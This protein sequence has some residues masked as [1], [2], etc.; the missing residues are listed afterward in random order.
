MEKNT[1]TALGWVKK[2]FSESSVKSI[3]ESV[4]TEQFNQLTVQAEKVLDGLQ[5]EL[6]A[7]KAAAVVNNETIATLN[8]GI[9]ASTKRETEA[10]ARVLALE[11]AL[12]VEKIETG[13]YKEL[14]DAD[15][16][17]GN[18]LPAGDATTVAM[19]IF[20]ALPEGDPTR[21]AA[22]KLLKKG[23]KPNNQ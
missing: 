11:I 23:V 16:S 20:S 8:A 6:S 10:S 18:A 3:S 15:I 21:A 9:E 12:S 14:Y 22:E 4:T 7:L 1:N 17:K 19:G 13:K 2:L 5:V